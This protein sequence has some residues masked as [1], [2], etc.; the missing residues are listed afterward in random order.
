M[1]K[2]PSPRAA[3]STEAG[4]DITES[5][6]L[7]GYAT[8]GL[9]SP[10]EWSTAVE[11]QDRGHQQL[12]HFYWAPALSHVR[13]ELNRLDDLGYVDSRVVPQGRVK[14]TM[15][16]RITD[17]GSKALA[18]WAERPDFDPLVIKNAVILRLWLGRRA[19]NAHQVLQAL[20]R[21][22]EH[23]E[24][25]LTAL[26]EEID[27]S[28]DRLGERESARTEDTDSDDLQVLRVRTAWHR[29]VMQYCRRGYENELRNSAELLA[30]LEAIADADER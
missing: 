23:V 14:R 26:D 30:E 25:E 21:H 20:K 9:L 10:N 24:G 6:P 3:V 4:G 28:R 16:Y 27:S 8:L 12:R 13:R 15:K 5:L 29:S 19:D 7:T 2:R 11:V 18:E 22:I 17:L 1:A